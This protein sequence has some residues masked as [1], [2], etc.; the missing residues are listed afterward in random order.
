MWRNRLPPLLAA[1]LISLFVITAG[2]SVRNTSSTWDE[3]FHL[4]A[5]VSYLQTGDPRLNWDH[6][7]L[8]RLIASLAVLAIP[9][10]PIAKQSPLAWKSADVLNAPNGSI[11]AMEIRLLWPARLMM[12]S[13][14]VLL[15]ILLYAWGS[16]LFGP[17]AAL[18]PLALYAFCP[19]LL[20]NAPIVATDLTITT[21]MFASIYAWWHYLQTLSR[22]W[23]LWTCLFVSLSFTAKF[24]AVALIPIFF[25]LGAFSF[26]EDAGPHQPGFRRR[27]R[28]LGAAWLAIGLAVWFGINLLYLFDGSFLTPPEYLVRVKELHPHLRSS[29]EKLNQIW[30]S[31]LPIPL[32]L[33]YTLG[34]FSRLTHL[35]S[36]HLTYFLGEVSN[37]GWPNYFLVMLLIK[38]PLASLFLIGAGM[39]LAIRRLPKGTL[40]LAFLLLPIGLLLW[41]ASSGKLQIGIRHILPIL[42]FLL[43]LSGYLL[44]GQ[45]SYRRHILV[46]LLVA[47]AAF[48]SFSV[49]PYYLMYFNF[50][51]GGPDQGWR[52]SIEGDDWGQGGADLVR[53]LESHKIKHLAYGP[54]GWST[55]PLRRAGISTSTVPC[56]DKGE[57][58]A[59][60]LGHLLKATAPEQARCY[61]WMRLRQPDEK[62]GYSIFLYNTKNSPKPPHP[63]N[64]LLF[65]QA[66]TLQLKGEKE[67]SISL[68]RQ[69]LLEEPEYF[70]AHF[71]LA[72]ALKDTG[73]C[74]EAIPEFE[75]TLTLWSGYK[76]A[77]LHIASCYD[78]LG[79]RDKAQWH[80]NR[81]K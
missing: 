54:F 78:E 10:D 61:T 55:S 47:S 6:P 17:K 24:T 37:G 28:L 44:Q 40:D 13:L 53:W 68:Y 45:V 69:Y 58:V 9:I 59:V 36:G 81:Y 77:H 50:L 22:G 23:L 4:A 12:L 75:R 20:A 67:Q 41:I 16:R 64:L 62:I 14:A 26:L 3:P 11:D 63:A 76:E 49:Y 2:L 31:W 66:L 15:G 51:A 42:P 38:L 48:S 5:G 33:F 18:L 21:L 60:H 46:G 43:L 30:S 73:R 57:L 72:C 27:F 39:L 8:A 7:P 19:P 65:N 52:I 32:P 1:V 70:Q 74:A 71:N 34:F 56:E 79:Q 35:E 80:L 25:L 29:A